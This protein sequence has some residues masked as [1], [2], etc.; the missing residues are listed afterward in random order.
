MTSNPYL[1][2]NI[3]IFNKRQ[4][5]KIQYSDTSTG[6]HLVSFHFFLKKK[7]TFLKFKIQPQKKRKKK[8]PFPKDSTSPPTKE[9]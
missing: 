1:I 2:D 8:V 7:G 5:L 9:I 4:D 3:S 6:T